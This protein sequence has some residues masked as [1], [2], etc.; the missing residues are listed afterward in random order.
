MYR[1]LRAIREAAEI[2]QIEL[3]R[4]VGVTAACINKIEAGTRNPSLKLA[5]LLE[6]ALGKSI[7][8][9]METERERETA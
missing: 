3:A 9:L 5:L 6:K 7:D 8:K 4:R 2:P 1:N